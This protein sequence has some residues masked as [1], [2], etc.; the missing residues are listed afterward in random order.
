M[1]PSR[2]RR[3]KP[4]SG[5]LSADLRACGNLFRIK[6]R[7]RL[8]PQTDKFLR[9]SGPAEGLGAP[10]APPAAPVLQQGLLFVPTPAPRPLCRVQRMRV[11]G[12][13][14]S[15]LRAGWSRP[16][17][18]AETAKRVEPLFAAQLAWNPEAPSACEARR[19]TRSRVRRAAGAP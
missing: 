4:E 2:M 18:Q 17:G 11:S 15:I 10:D 16:A 8:S 1:K 12:F 19:G 13:R 14:E 6:L 3:R 9:E 7:A 5:D